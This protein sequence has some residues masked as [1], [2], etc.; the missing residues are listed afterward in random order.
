LIFRQP[1]PQ[2]G[3]FSHYKLYRDVNSGST[4][5]L[6]YESPYPVFIDKVLDTATAYKYKVSF[7][8]SDGDQQVETDGTIRDNS[9]NGYTPDNADNSNLTASTFLAQNIVAVNEVR[10][11]SIAAV[12]L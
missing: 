4:W 12:H 6:V 8:Y 9:S 2:W 1:S 10:G 7:V 11:D 3:S 5:D